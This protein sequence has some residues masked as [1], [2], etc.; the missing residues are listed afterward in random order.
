MIKPE[1]TVLMP[2]YNAEKYL[3]E[4][5][6]S[7]LNQTFT[8]FEFLII[9]D[10]STDSSVNLI[11]SFTDARIK[12][13]QNEN[14]SGIA[15]TLNRGIN[16]AQADWIARMD[17]DDICFPDRLQKQYDF[18]KSHPD[19]AL[20]SCWAAEVTEN[21]D[22]IGIERFNPLHYYY[23]LPFVPWIFHPTMV[24]KREAVLAIGKY[25]VPYA[26]DYELTWQLTRQFKMYHLPEVLLEYR[27]TGQGLWQGQK[28]NENRAS[29][30]SQV[31]RNILY[32]LEDPGVTL[33]DWQID[34]LSYNPGL[35]LKQ[36]KIKDL[37]YCLHLLDS[38]TKKILAKENINR[39]PEAIKEAAKLKREHLL[40]LS[41][42]KLGKIKGTILVLQAGGWKL[43][44]RV[45]FEKLGQIPK[46]T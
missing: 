3:A 16:L 29:F 4:A 10:R 46:R 18:I 30:L 43:F 34:Y 15:A 13:F 27:V 8:N 24:Y 41:V 17:A 5:I 28:K 2:V 11:L 21:R 45:I 44:W 26:E 25:T 23:N 6:A 20:F 39:V 7:V 22:L 36:H 37:L 19:G 35:E 33:E 38:I 31:R 14:N 40:L 42:A 32:Y 1:I 12:F 9:D